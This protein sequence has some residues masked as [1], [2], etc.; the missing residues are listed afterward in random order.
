M[1]ALSNK[2]LKNLLAQHN[3]K[4]KDIK[5]SGKNNIVL[6]SDRVKM[7]KKLQ[8]KLITVKGKQYTEEFLYQLIQQYDNV[9]K[10][11]DYGY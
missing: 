10:N 1:N 3:I 5:G 4:D 9:T 2:E 8:S 11:V 7:A 6:K